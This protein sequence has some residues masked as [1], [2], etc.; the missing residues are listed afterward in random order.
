MIKQRILQLKNDSE[1]KKLLQERD[2][3]R[4]AKA[5]LLSMQKGIEEKKAEIA[6][7]IESK[8]AQLREKILAGDDDHADIAKEIVELRKKGEAIAVSEA[9]LSSGL[10][11]VYDEQ[12]EGI[13]NE[14]RRRVIEL[15]KPI[16]DEEQ[17]TKTKILDGLIE[18]HKTWG[19]A[20][21][22]LDKKLGL[23]VHKGHP[24]HVLHAPY[25]PD[26]ETRRRQDVE[27]MFK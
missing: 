14:I 4:Q 19:E 27:A 23:K 25:I 8:N 13:E 10:T 2:T 20:M 11:S 5:R 21:V 12:I 3:V 6:K 7:E 1:I 18:R 22:E 24:H 9:Q 15:L 16:W 26:L 17:D